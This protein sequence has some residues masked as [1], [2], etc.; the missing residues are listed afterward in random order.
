[1]NFI[2]ATVEHKSAITDPINIYGL[3]YCGADVAVPGTGSNADVRFR[4][5]CYKREGA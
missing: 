3:E 4:A 1:M 2:A 5:L